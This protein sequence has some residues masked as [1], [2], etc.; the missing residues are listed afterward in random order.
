MKATEL[1][2]DIRQCPN[3][4]KYFETLGWKTYKTSGSIQI[5]II[6][7]LLGSLAKIQRP[8]NVTKQDLEEIDRI[9]GENK[10]LFVK[11]EL[12]VGQDESI[13]DE[14]GYGK[15]YF[16]LV[17]PST[18]YIDME[19]TEEELWNNLSHSAK[20]SIN[21][22][23]RENACIKIFQNPA[24]ETLK[25]YYAV[26]K[27]T[28][29]KKRF[30]VQPFNDLKNR[31]EIFDNQA[32]LIMVYDGNGGLASAK[33]YQADC[34]EVLYVHGG[35]SEAGRKNKA[36]YELMWKSILY[37][38]QLGYKI[39]DLEGLDDSRFRFYTNNWGG[40][41]H[42]KEKFGGEIVKFPIP[43]VKYFHPVFKTLAR[44]TPL[45]L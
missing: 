21:R 43:R 9:C 7:T 26:L 29:Q 16:P 39:L 4:A 23:Q 19:L 31:V 33:F 34:D 38:K 30:Y 40:F 17:P 8:K 25:E 24:E 27:E 10:T 41:S 44:Y 2:Q 12:N 20:Y 5:H 15:S 1:K 18:M 28:A 36:G 42:F 3:W 35:T 14:M 37:F 13:F 11:I 6:K 22:A 32:F 45:P